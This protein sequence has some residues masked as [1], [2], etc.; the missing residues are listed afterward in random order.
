MLHQARNQL[1]LPLALWASELVR[2][3]CRGADVRVQ[4]IQGAESAMAEI[5]LVGSAV[6]CALCRIVRHHAG[7]PAFYATRDRNRRHDR[8]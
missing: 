6:E 4:R 7:R 1:V 3:M 5:A 2:V 8:E